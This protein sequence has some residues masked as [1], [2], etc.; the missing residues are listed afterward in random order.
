MARPP[1]QAEGQSRP[2]EKRPGLGLAQAW[3]GQG[4]K[5]PQEKSLNG[6]LMLPLPHP[7][8]R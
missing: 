6:A 4:R 1:W 8:L 5:L 3:S 2:P 7:K